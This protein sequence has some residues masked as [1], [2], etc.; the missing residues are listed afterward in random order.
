M[1]RLELLQ[2]SG[3][4]TLFT[5]Q[6]GF[7]FCSER[8]ELVCKS[9]SS[10]RELARR[11]K[12]FTGFGQCTGNVFICRGLRFLELCSNVSGTAAERQLD[13]PEY[14]GR[15][16]FGVRRQRRVV[17]CLH[18]RARRAFGNWC[19]ESAMRALQIELRWEAAA[20]AEFLQMPLSVVFDHV[21][22][23]SR[24]QCCRYNFKKGYESYNREVPCVSA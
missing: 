22:Y 19:S 9:V 23:R 6:G 5:V 20:V 8:G 21:M 17:A 15:L 10:E 12:V 4:R 7:Q 13:M 11:G 24:A 14:E 18:S 1:K 2:E 3:L 16:P